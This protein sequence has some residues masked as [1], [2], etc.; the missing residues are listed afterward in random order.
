MQY[1]INPKNNE[2]LSSLGF[3][4]MRFNKDDN[5]VER[6][7][8]YAI[9]NGVNYFDTAYM[10]TGNEARLGKILSK[11]GL[12]DKVNIATKLPQYL[13]KNRADIEKM[14]NTE[15]ERLQTDRIGYYLMHMMSD[16]DSW[17]RLEELGIVEW[18]EEKKRSGQ[19]RNIGFSFHGVAQEFVNIIDAY[20]WDFCMIQYNYLDENY[21]AGNSGLKYA[22]S[23]GLPVIIM[24]PLRGGTLV[25]KLPPAAQNVWD[26]APIKRSY[27][28]WGLRW[29]WNHPEVIC[30]LSG[31]G[32]QEMVE[33]NIRIASEAKAS[34]LNEEELK[35]YDI[36]RTK[37]RE[38]TKV[39]C[40]GCGYCV[41]CPKGVDIPM[42]FSSLNDTVIKGR[43]MSMYWYIL[44]TKG[45]NASKCIKCGNCEKHCPQSIP[46]RKKLDQTKKELEGF[47]YKPMKFIMS[48]LL[49]SM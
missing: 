39:T 15:L 43:F 12:R 36:A 9:D 19:I 3:G 10:Y 17:Y 45:H 5:E 40:T 42:C 31:M 4:C 7:I 26:N 27:A 18:I 38:A 46:I 24:E 28:D 32:T 6:Q 30:V 2:R 33:E 23:K 11:D 41:P 22:A 48:K 47:P 21:Q 20:E 14:F 1:R 13:V 16:V 34:I 8:R 25:D 49:K 44:T 35:L 37:I 29:V